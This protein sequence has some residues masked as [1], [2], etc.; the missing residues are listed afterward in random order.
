MVPIACRQPN[1]VRLA[2]SA[3]QPWTL[4]I[5]M[6]SLHIRLKLD[7]LSTGIAADPNPESERATPVDDVS[8]R[9]RPCYLLQSIL[10][11]HYLL[12][13][14]CGSHARPGALVWT[15]L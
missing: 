5:A 9:G 6:L 3:G 14:F 7:V 10:R 1:P 4:H 13:G 15:L 11:R 12:K 2:P 8:H